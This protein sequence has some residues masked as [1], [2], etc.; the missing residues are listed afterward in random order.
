MKRWYVIPVILLIVAVPTYL[1]LFDEGY[2]P[3]IEELEDGKIQVIGDSVFG[4][5]A[6]GCASIAGFMS[7]KLEV[8][9]TDHAI[10]G[11]TVIG[12]DGI[13]SQYV[14]GDWEWTVIDGGGN[15]AMAYCSE[16]DDDECDEKLD[17]IMTDD[18]K[19]LIPNLIN[20]AKNDGSQVIILGYYSVPKGSEFEDLV[21][22]IEILNDRY[23]EFAEANDDVYFISLKDVMTPETTPIYY[24]DDLV[25]PSEEGHKAIGEYIADFI[26]NKS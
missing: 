23:K 12:E 11:A 19:G 20:K 9:V 25:H 7:M 4:S 14:S 18:N 15:D 2:C 10:P 21:L 24:S 5:D 6:D 26:T 16:G 3:D 17:E 1:F 22:E 8:K 13:P